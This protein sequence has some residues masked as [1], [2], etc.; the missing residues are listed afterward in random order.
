MPAGAGYFKDE[1]NVYT[2]GMFLAEKRSEH[3][4]MRSERDGKRVKKAHQYIPFRA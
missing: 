2:N 1:F 4:P 3:P